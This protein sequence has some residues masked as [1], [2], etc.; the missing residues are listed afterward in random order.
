MSPRRALCQ[1]LESQ[2]LQ[3][4]TG[5]PVV[6]G[7]PAGPAW[8]SSMVA[9]GAAQ[10]FQPLS[11]ELAGSGGGNCTDSARGLYGGGAPRFHLHTIQQPCLGPTSG[12][13][14][15]VPGTLPEWRCWP[16][17]STPLGGKP[18]PV[19]ATNSW[20]GWSTTWAGVDGFSHRGCVHEA[21][22]FKTVS[23]R[24]YGSGH[25]FLPSVWKP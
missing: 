10:G 19:R 6:L 1:R 5:C 8:F 23:G 12:T 3:W 22:Y 18:S 16:R 13:N 2:M 15:P 9:A 17:I 11:V 24:S 21:R 4:G 14:R 25:P 20:C 7:K